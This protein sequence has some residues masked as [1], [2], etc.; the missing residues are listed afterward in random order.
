MTAGIAHRSAR[1]R[2]SYI[3]ISKYVRTVLLPQQYRS[4]CTARRNIANNLN[5]QCTAHRSLSSWKL[6]QRDKSSSHPAEPPYSDALADV[7]GPDILRNWTSVFQDF[8]HASSSVVSNHQSW[9]ELKK[10]NAEWNQSPPNDPKYTNPTF[11]LY[12]YV[13]SYRPTTRAHFMQ[14][15]DPGLADCVQ[16]VLN[17][18][19]F[20]D[21]RKDKPHSSAAVAPRLK[22]KDALAQIRPH[23]P[24]SVRGQLHVRKQKYTRER[25]RGGS[26]ADNTEVWPE[27]T[28]SITD[29]YTGKLNLLQHLEIHVLAIE[30]LNSWPEGLI[31][32]SDTQFPP[33]Q[34]HL[35][36]RTKEDLRGRL[37][38]RSELHAKCTEHLQKE[39]FQ[40]VETPL[41]FKSTPEG[42]REYLVPTRQK[43]LAYALPQSPQ[44]YKQV[45]MASGVPKYF[46]F[47]RCFRDEDLRADRQPEFTQLD[48]EMAFADSHKVMSTVEKL[49]LDVMWPL[50]GRANLLDLERDTHFGRSMVRSISTT[51][52]KLPMI[53]YGHAMAKYG[54]DKPDPRWGA[55]IQNISFIPDQSKSMLSSLQDPT[56][57]MFKLSMRDSPPSESRG[58]VSEFMKLPSSAQFSTNP[59]GIPGIAIFDTSTPLNGLSTFGFE[60][61]T[62]IEEMFEPEPGDIL[63]AQTRQRKPFSGGS[64][65]LGQIRQR[66]HEL[67]VK[68]ALIDAPKLDS[69][70]WV[71]DFPLFSP[72]EADSPGQGGSA[73]ICSTHHPFTA[74]KPGQDL[75]KLISSPL[76][77]I[78]D[79]YDLVVNG[80]E[81]G[82]GSRR[83]HHSRMQEVIFRDVL[84]MRPERIE[85]FRHL[86]NA[87]EAGCPPHAGFALGFDRLVALLTN[88]DSVRDVIA[89]PK[90]QHGRDPFV[91]SPSTLSEEQLKT[92]HLRVLDNNGSVPT[93][94]KI[95]IK[96]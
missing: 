42:A 27:D 35:S 4:C 52:L 65:T 28:A 16:L 48:L 59:E 40:E 44:Q 15:V 89:F 69:L 91:G 84:K 38:L 46:Q 58:F 74:P 34:R 11:T 19:D 67:A 81:V 7:V 2:C 68:H 83:I 77:V 13:T 10:I 70:L 94:P 87:L 85:D 47:A 90:Y 93:E 36:F 3:E 41:L 5:T 25:F 55:E 24:V 60:A 82:G 32:D 80:V 1:L 17:T 14:L 8:D 54:S 78:G 73:G 71:V 18:G 12:G 22:F 9:Q 37:K 45:L 62:R 63:V 64:T 86:L 21:N 57:E 96:A 26:K 33:E 95:S 75:W 76:R 72:V 23:T 53:E 92:Y 6:R 30:P 61:A 31:A 50:A 43:G 29:P 66:M 49:I 51:G 79:H 20:V 39:D 56:V 88:T